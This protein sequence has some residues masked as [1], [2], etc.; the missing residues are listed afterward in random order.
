MFQRPL[1][2]LLPFLA[3]AYILVRWA[4]QPILGAFAAL[5]LEALQSAGRHRAAPSQSHTG[6]P[7]ELF[8]PALLA[9]LL[10]NAPWIAFLLRRWF[11]PHSPLRTPLTAAAA[12]ILGGLLGHQFLYPALLH[13][14]TSPILLPPLPAFVYHLH[15]AAVLSSALLA[16]A[17]PLAASRMR[18]PNAPVPR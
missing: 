18:G 9:A 5:T 1:A 8:Y 3:T 7:A 6:P 10:L 17:L 11:F 15:A 2:V 16:A 12:F 14:G 4:L 13:S